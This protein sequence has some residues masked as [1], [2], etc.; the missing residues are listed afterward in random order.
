MKRI[1]RNSDDVSNYKQIGDV[2]RSFDNNMSIINIAR[3]LNIKIF[4]VN[5]ILKNNNRKILKRE[6]IKNINIEDIQK[7]IIV[8]TVLGDGCLYKTGHNFTLSFSHCEKQKEYFYWKLEML[9]PFI[10]N[11]SINIDK[12]GNSIMHHGTTISHKD[13]NFFGEIFYDQN[14]IKHIP[15]DLEKYLTPIALA[16]WILDDGNLNEEVNMRIASMGFTKEENYMLIDYL[17]RCYDL[18]SDIRYYNRKDKIYPL[19]VLDKENT[20]KLSDIIRPY[21]VDSM[22]YKLMSESSTTNMSNI[23]NKDEDIV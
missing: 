4:R 18:D 8:G 15:R 7:Q 2:L 13:L 21:V 14:R 9:S 23:L 1:I 20:Q 11:F 19:I 6:E 12:R 22:K 17:K 3:N 10:S 16:V 5:E